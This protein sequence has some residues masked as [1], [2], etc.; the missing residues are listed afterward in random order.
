[1]IILD[2]CKAISI[3]VNTALRM[4]LTL[5]TQ[6]VMA[7]TRKRTMPLPRKGKSYMAAARREWLIVNSNDYAYLITP[8]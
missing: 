4:S 5:Q 7:L 6:A 1:M 3:K 8:S 2:A